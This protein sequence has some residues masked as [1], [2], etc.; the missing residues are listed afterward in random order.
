MAPRSISALTVIAPTTAPRPWARR[1]SAMTPTRDG[2]N[3]VLLSRR[4][5]GQFARAA[6]GPAVAKFDPRWVAHAAA[7]PL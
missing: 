3:D 4:L 1:A 2:G 6:A 7:V 5:P